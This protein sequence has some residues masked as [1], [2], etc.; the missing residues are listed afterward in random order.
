MQ[1]C[2]PRSLF[3]PSSQPFTTI[4]GSVRLTIT[5]ARAVEIDQAIAYPFNGDEQ[6]IKLR[7]VCGFGYRD[8]GNRLDVSKDRAATG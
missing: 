3:Y 6:A 7:F 2:P 5:D 4:K 1:A 8:I